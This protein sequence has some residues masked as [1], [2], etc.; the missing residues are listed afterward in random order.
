MANIIQVKALE[1]ITQL[2]ASINEHGADYVGGSTEKV[3]KFELWLDASELAQLDAEANEI[4]DFSFDIVWDDAQLQALGWG[5]TGDQLGIDNSFVSY[6]YN[7]ANDMA[8]TFNPDNNGVASIAFSSP[9]SV[10]DTLTPMFGADQKGTEILI[11]TF[12]TNPVDQTAES[13]SIT[14]QGINIGTNLPDSIDL[15]DVVVNGTSETDPNDGDS[16]N[17]GAD[18][19]SKDVSTGG[20]FWD[21]QVEYEDSTKTFIFDIFESGI[22]AER[23]HGGGFGTVGVFAA[24]DY[25]FDGVEF[26][27]SGGAD[28]NSFYISEQNAPSYTINSTEISSDYEIPVDVGGD[29][30]FNFTV[31]A[32]R[33][34]ITESYSIVI[35]ILDVNEIEGDNQD[36]EL[37]GSGNVDLITTGLGDDLVDAGDGNDLIV[38][39]GGSNTL[40]GGN[41]EDSIFLT[42]NSTWSS[43]YSALNADTG[44]ATG[45]GSRVSL[46]GL[47]KFNDVINGGDGSDNLVLSDGSD[48]FFIEDVYSGHHVSLTLIETDNGH[49]STARVLDIESIKAGSGH[50]IVDLTSSH[51]VLTDN[52][53]IL[54]GE[55]NDIIWAASGSDQINGGEGDDTL[56]GGAGN[57]TLTGGSGS[58]TFQFTATSESDVITDFDI[59]ED[60]I[61]LYY[62]TQDNHSNDD[63]SLSNGVLTWSAGESSVLIDMSDTITSSDL[64]NHDSLITFVEIV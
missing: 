50:D 54:G 11:A 51:F 60:S 37:Q 47:N 30:Q 44:H 32:S 10:V 42:T 61:E 2:Q 53:V 28:A 39:E 19:L 16:N 8:I 46:E 1:P 14:I 17:S 45:T 23:P 63:L 27:I 4:F 55:G 21:P 56:F 7:N 59:T 33:D 20:D 41:G 3:V 36:N 40:S 52:T 64:N 13:V 22:S 15:D 35:N 9:N 34:D 5:V 31:E 24:T 48:V 62:R 12:Y 29:H 26:V 57:D 38:A 6:N 18:I 58:D 49:S 43:G 25:D